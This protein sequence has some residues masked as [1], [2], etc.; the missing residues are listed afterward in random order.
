MV[1][2]FLERP[3]LAASFSIIITLLGVLALRLLPLEQFPRITPPKITVSTRFVGATA[4]TVAESVAAPL[5]RT[6]NGAK[7]MIY[8]FSEMGSDGYLHTDLYFDIGTNPNKALSDTQNRVNLA[9]ESLPEEVKKAGLDVKK[10]TSSPFLFIAI[11][12]PLDLYD[13]L[14]ISNYAS[15]NIVEELKRIKGIGTVDVFNAQSYAMRIWIQPDRLANY[16]LT[17]SNVSQAIITQSSLRPIGQIGQEPASKEIRL[18]IPID[19][20][21]Q[22]SDAKQFEKIVLRTNA[23]GSKI[24]LSDIGRIELGTE[25]Y[26]LVGKLNGQKG[27][28]IRVYLTPDANALLV[29]KKIKNRMGELAPF[30]PPKMTYSFPYDTSLFIHASIRELERSVLEAAVIVALVIFLFLQSVRATLVPLLAMI[31]SIIGS[32]I[33]I[34]LMGLSINTLTLFGLV[35]AIGIVVDD[36]IVV[37]ESIEKNM[38]DLG[39]SAKE[40]ARKTMKEVARPIIA[41][42][43]ILCSVFIPVALIG[44]IPGKFYKHSALAISFSVII[45]GFVSLTLSPVLSVLLLTNHKKKKSRFSQSFNRI[46]NQSTDS[47]IRG[48][49]WVLKHKF[50]G[51]TLFVTILGLMGLLAV[52]VPIGFIPEEDQGLFGIIANLPDGA[53]L[54]RTQKVCEKITDIVLKSPATREI[55]TFSGWAAMESLPISSHAIAFVLLKDWKERKT[56][57]LAAS[58][59]MQSLNEQFSSIPEAEILAMGPPQVPGLGLVTGFSFWILNR[60]DSSMATL[61]QVVDKILE[62]AEK[63]HEFRKLISTIQAN[64]IEVF[65][66]LDKQKALSLDVDLNQIYKSLQ[67]IFGSSTLGHF[68]KSGKDVKV[69]MQANPNYYETIKGIDKAFVSSRTNQMIPLNTFITPRISS[70]STAQSRFNGAP[71]ALISIIPGSTPHKTISLMEEISKEFL[72]PGM[73]FEWGGL[74]YEEKRSGGASIGALLGGFFVVFLVLAALYERWLLPLAVLLIVPFAIFGALLAVW[75]RNMH[76]DLYFQIGIIALIGL[77]AKNAILIIE[78][79]RLKRAEG[80]PLVEAALM[81]ARMRFRAIIMTSLTLVFGTLPLIFSSGPGAASR[82]SVGTGIIGGMLMA[83]F[84]AIFFVPLFYI[85][86]EKHIKQ[87]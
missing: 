60:G 81:G 48:A 19:T 2:F 8:M 1:K 76:N 87:K 64:S 61:N 11:Q 34:Y 82:N 74:A 25:N 6:L 27:S 52:K 71:A 12:A 41:I 80:L 53:S 15:N 29:A 67:I 72:L 49:D 40:A 13:D 9:L 38:K 86:I 14:F 73:S 47:Y 31:V 39:L 66:E 30:F 57:D 4:E 51:V 68:T 77:S 75:A 21:G 59:V 78:Y 44:G 65:L 37:V 63:R 5:E 84:L 35:V 54:D 36:A 56:K 18:T 83:T 16:N 42:T 26:G 10:V 32:F 45:S 69:I 33:G 28:F 70:G 24:Y 3:I 43:L 79:A 7:N 22:L 50:T 85:M 20:L 17:L 46:L 23:D 62:K 58:S 55:L